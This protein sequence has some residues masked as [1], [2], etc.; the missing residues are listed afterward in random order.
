LIDQLI[1]TLTWLER[2]G[3]AVI[4]A[5]TIVLA[6]STIGLWRATR[7]L[8]EA[9][10]QQ[11]AAVGDIAEAAKDLAE[12]TRTVERAYV[13]L[14]QT[15]AATAR[16]PLRTKA[17]QGVESW[18]RNNLAHA[19]NLDEATENAAQWRGLKPY[20]QSCPLF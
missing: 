2:H 6:L 12:H 4:A 17:K 19:P 5:F 7:K 20:G 9:G 10:E 1:G 15:D 11:I 18:N 13:K 3:E 16:N 14:S 8:Y